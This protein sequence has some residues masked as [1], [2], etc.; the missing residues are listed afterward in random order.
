MS[1]IRAMGD[2]TPPGLPLRSDDPMLPRDPYGRH[3]LAIERALQAAARETGL[4]L[5][6]LRPPL[7]Y[8]PGV[9]GNFRLLIQ[10]VAS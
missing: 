8:G 1:S 4:E 2:V 7:V 9:R 5:V 10:L 3:K 6:I